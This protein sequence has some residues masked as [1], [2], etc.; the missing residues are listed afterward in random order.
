M[1][2]I[3]VTGGAGFIGSH[4]SLLLLKKGFN[5]II[6]DSFLNSNPKVIERISKLS[7]IKNIQKRIDLIKGDIRDQE[8]LERIFNFAKINNNPI[9]A[10]IHFAGLKS[11]NDSL[12]NA[13][14]YWDVNVL[15]TITLLKVMEKNNCFT[16]IFSSSATI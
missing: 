9:D 10:V 6:L 11:V 12:E 7:G 2:T 8:L 15:G 5:L 3:L 1:K 14:D 16:I 13:L 4:T